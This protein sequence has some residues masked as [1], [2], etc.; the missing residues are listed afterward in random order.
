MVPSDLREKAALSRATELSEEGTSA[1]KTWQKHIKVVD[2]SRF[3]WGTV[4]NYQS[5]PLADDEKQL[6]HSEKE[7]EHE[8]KEFEEANKQWRSGGREGWRQ[9][10]YPYSF[11]DPQWDTAGPSSRTCR[12]ITYTTSAIDVPHTSEAD[13]AKSP[14]P[15][16]T[17][18]AFGH[19]AAS[20]PLKGK[21]YPFGQ[22]VVSSAEVTGVISELSESSD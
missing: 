7:A 14:G 1:L 10:P 22:P 18:G 9:W 19:L 11:W 3:G 2:H 6:R 21:Q 20:C 4:R 13:Q 8:F 17:C 5:D 12:N 16:F 15:C